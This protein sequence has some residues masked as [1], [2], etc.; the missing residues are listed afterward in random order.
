NAALD[1][2]RGGLINAAAGFFV[3]QKAIGGPIKAAMEFES[4]MADL[5]KVSSFDDAGLKKFSKTLRMI[6]TTEIPM[7]LT[8]L[9]ALA[10]EA[11]KAG[12]SEGELEEFTKMVA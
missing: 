11:S 3:L 8:E 2:A 1:H 6:A 4:G 10:T 5:Q 12:V 9:T 7:A